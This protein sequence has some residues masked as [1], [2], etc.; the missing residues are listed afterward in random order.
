MRRRVL[1]RGACALVMI[2][3]V[4]G[5]GA[6]T[7]RAAGPD[8]DR[9]V[10]LPT[11][12]S[13]PAGDRA[14][15][16]SGTTGDA[17]SADSLLD[18]LKLQGFGTAEMGYTPS[19]AGESSLTEVLEHA[20]SLGMKVSINPCGATACD[21]SAVTLATGMQQLVTYDQPVTAPS[22]GYVFTGSPP[23]TKMPGN[24]MLV[25]VTAAKVSGSSGTQVM[26]D[27]ATAID[28][29]ADVSGG[30]LH[31]T[32]PTAGT[33]ELFAFYSRATGQ[34]VNPS[35]FD[36]PS[37]WTAR[38]PAVGAASGR[39]VADI[40]Q[41]KGLTD[42]LDLMA[43]TVFGD[44]N[45][46]RM[47]AMDTS[48]FHDSLEVQAQAFW[49]DDLPQQFQA[50]RGYS[51]IRYLPALDNVAASSFNPLNPANPMPIP[52]PPFDFTG[53]VGGR[54]RYD[55]DRTLTDLY[56]ERYAHAMTRWGAPAWPEVSRAAGLQLHRPGR[57]SGATAVDIPETES[58]DP[59][60]AHPFD[61]T[62]P[63][64]GTNR[65][66]YYVDAQRLMSSGAHISQKNRVTMEWGDDFDTY[67]K[68][69]LELAD[70]MN[71]AVSVGVTMP[72][73]VGFGGVDNSAYPQPCALCFI[74]LGGT[75][76]TNTPQWKDFGALAGYFART[77]QVV[78]KGKP[79]VDVTVY[80][81]G[82]PVVRARR[83]RPAVVRPPA[84]RSRVHV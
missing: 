62:L 59:G 37:T 52:P 20:E 24:P 71:A 33:W 48:I 51:M 57:H 30:T 69:P 13:P 79:M 64:Y 49:T 28:L 25:A 84:W 53:G 78:E 67:N 4:M 34:Y 55:Y 72:S 14:I 50:R 58:L 7:S 16:R 6:G 35:P 81:D 31:W 76:T 9:V 2:A 21:S 15:N 38:D 80:H 39:L 73:F 29:T 77:T 26:M 66:Q 60:W 11:F 83:Q 8:G 65:G 68:G 41:S 61:S 36:A 42:S 63:S 45:Q 40:F 54:F 5:V 3:G 82:G 32:I 74:G 19:P 23:A 18:Q 43:N 17:A 75:M 27:P 47:D 70:L 10:G 56:V 12:Q 44:G 1:S 22:D 46:A